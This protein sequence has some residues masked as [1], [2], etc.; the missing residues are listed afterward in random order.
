MTATVTTQYCKCFKCQ[1]EEGFEVEGEVQLPRAKLISFY[2]C[3]KCMARNP[4]SHTCLYPF[5]LEPDQLY[6][7]KTYTSYRVTDQGKAIPQR[8][9]PTLCNNPTIG[10][11]CISYITIED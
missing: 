2:I 3:K 10:K 5:A 4:C 7:M 8:H 6:E 9:V 1:A 11:M